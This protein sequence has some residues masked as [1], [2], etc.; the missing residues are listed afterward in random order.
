MN[1]DPEFAQVVRRVAEMAGLSLDDD[2]ID[3]LGPLLEDM[4]SQ[5]ETMRRLD[6]DSVE[7]LEPAFAF[8]PAAWTN[9]PS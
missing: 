7:Q 9:R 4:M 5:F 3:K 8:L 1:G 2:R 6:P